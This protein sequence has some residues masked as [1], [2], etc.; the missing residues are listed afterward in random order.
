M[1]SATEPLTIRNLAARFDRGLLVPIM[2]AAIIA[3][4]ML[5]FGLFWS[6]KRSDTVSVGRQVRI[7]QR[8]VETSLAA[9]Q[10]QQQT[11]ALY[12]E[13][14]VKLRKPTPDADWMDANVGLWLHE[15]F[16]HDRVFL[17][18]ADNKVAYAM[19]DGKRVQATLADQ[20][21]LGLSR[22][23][24]SL[25]ATDRAFTLQHPTPGDASPVVPFASDLLIIEGHPAAVSAMLVLPLTP[26]VADRPG[27]RHILLSV[28]YLDGDFRERLA[29]EYLLASP[30]FSIRHD[31]RPAR[32][33][34]GVARSR[35]AG[36]RLAFLVSGA[37]GI[38]DQI[39]A[40]P[41]WHALR[42]RDCRLDAVARP[43]AD[44]EHP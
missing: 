23:I 17:L 13:L 26:A 6:A 10:L 22:L 25:R 44:R 37:A 33:R 41:A 39:R 38:G 4:A 42:R 32:K 27:A 1:V 31:I 5:A 43:P 2:L 9:I 35:R 8:A 30:R 18:D 34:T 24:T 20:N 14:V 3:I 21:G 40:A 36:V 12:D 7:V 11:V 16:G 28:R 19:V 15:L 29:R